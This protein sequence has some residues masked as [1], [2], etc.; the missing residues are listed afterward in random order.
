MIEIAGGILLALVVLALLP[1][2][3]GL[4]VGV[5]FLVQ[6]TLPYLLLVVSGVWLAHQ[7]P[8]LREPWAWGLLGALVAG[9]LSFKARERLSSR[10]DEPFEWHQGHF[11]GVGVVFLLGLPL[12]SYFHIKTSKEIRR[13][14]GYDDA[15]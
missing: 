7:I 6:A 9:Y 11:S 13:N 1:L 15:K 8:D 12:L 2:L 4:T 14:A 5:A 10:R 3:F